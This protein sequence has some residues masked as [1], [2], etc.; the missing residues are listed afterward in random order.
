[1][2]LLVDNLLEN[3]VRHGGGTVRVRLGPDSSAA[4][5]VV[6]D[7]GPGIRR[8]ERDRIFERF[9][10]GT[11]A[12]PGGSGLGL[13]IVAQQAAMHRGH[14]EVGESPLG[15]ARFAVRLPRD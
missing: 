1:M 9:A 14:V 15:G 12:K 10:R 2:R 4:E 3:A 13:A 11:A 8:E 6:D 5:L 7:D